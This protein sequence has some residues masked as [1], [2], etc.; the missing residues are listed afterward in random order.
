ASSNSFCKDLDIE[1]VHNTVK[2]TCT[3]FEVGTRM[4]SLNIGGEQKTSE[5]WLLEVA[6]LSILLCEKLGP[7]SK[8]KKMYTST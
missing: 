1:T 8:H 4:C 5:D 2:E 3:E 6:T 7:F